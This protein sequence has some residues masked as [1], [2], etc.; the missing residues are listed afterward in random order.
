[1][2]ASREKHRVKEVNC[3]GNGS[4]VKTLSGERDQ[5]TMTSLVDTNTVVKFSGVMSSGE[6][7]GEK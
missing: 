6:G 4:A 2:E 5:V 3:T 7:G 1:M